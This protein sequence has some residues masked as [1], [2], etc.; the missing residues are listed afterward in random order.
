MINNQ[1]NTP[2]NINVLVDIIRTVSV[3]EIMSLNRSGRVLLLL[4]NA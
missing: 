1:I 4:T 2:K 3:I